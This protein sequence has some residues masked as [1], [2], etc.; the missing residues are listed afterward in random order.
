MKT[1]SLKLSF[2]FCWAQDRV[3]RPVPVR[4]TKREATSPW[5]KDRNS[6]PRQTWQGGRRSRQG[7]LRLRSALSAELAAVPSPTTQWLKMN[8]RRLALSVALSLG[9]GVALQAGPILLTQS[10][11]ALPSDSAPP[12]LASWSCLI[13]EAGSPG[14]WSPHSLYQLTQRRDSPHPFHTQTTRKVALE[15][16]MS[17]PGARAEWRG[18]FPNLKMH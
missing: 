7:W 16:I 2:Q 5:P 4:M 15:V 1:L 8:S 6:L 13:R 11:L 10:T 12:C 3:E 18:C 9:P 14:V 17:Q